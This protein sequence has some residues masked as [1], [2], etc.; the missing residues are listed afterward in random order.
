MPQRPAPAAAACARV[1]AIAVRVAVRQR[2]PSAQACRSNAR[3]ASQQLTRARR[4]G[5]AC[6][7]VAVA[8]RRD[9]MRNRTR[10]GAFE[11]AHELQHA[12]AA[13][14]AEIDRHEP[15]VGATVGDAGDV[16]EGEVD[17]MKVIAHAGAIGCR[18]VIAPDVEPF[19]PADGDL[20]DERKQL[21]GTSCG[22]SPIR[23]LACAPIGSK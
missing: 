9:R 8:S 21:F 15:G 5:P 19:A 20:R 2:Q 3:P 23:P 22:S 13:A 4:I 16:P 6:G 14:G 11:G 12:G 17:H 10:R 1:S 18:P 7:D